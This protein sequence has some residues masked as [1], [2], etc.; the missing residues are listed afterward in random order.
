MP[1]M[2]EQ[3]EG[4]RGHLPSPVPGAQRRGLCFFA[5]WGRQNQCC[6]ASPTP[7]LPA[8]SPFLRVWSHLPSLCTW[9]SAPRSPCSFRGLWGSL[10]CC[11]HQRLF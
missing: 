9:L 3:A 11:S 1:T 8:Q 4:A 10:G 7:L 5:A 2:S 6:C